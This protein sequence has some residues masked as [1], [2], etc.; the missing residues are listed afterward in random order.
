[1]RRDHRKTTTKKKHADLSP[2]LGFLVSTAQCERMPTN[3][4]GNGSYGSLILAHAEKI[5]GNLFLKGK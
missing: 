1:M 4:N 5:I 2:V 3:Y